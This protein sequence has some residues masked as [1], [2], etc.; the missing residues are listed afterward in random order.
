MQDL[1]T[2]VWEYSKNNPYGFTLNL[3]TFTPIEKGFC[4]AY[5][6]TQDC[7]NIEGLEKAI[8]HALEHQ[9]IIGGWLDTLENKYYF[10]SIRIFETEKEALTFA[11]ENEQKAIFNLTNKKEI[12]L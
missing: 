12:R 11:K 10:D 3:E 2:R 4:V 7:F 5:K 1:T 8:T 9:K 6:E